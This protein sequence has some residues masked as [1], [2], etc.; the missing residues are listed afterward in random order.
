MDDHYHE[1][2][3]EVIHRVVD[4]TY[5][6]GGVSLWRTSGQPWMSDDR[7]I[8]RCATH[9]LA[10]NNVQAIGSPT[11]GA[12]ERTRRRRGAPQS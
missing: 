3:H 9:Y 10:I 8:A 4:V 11:V 6:N 5:V 7:F 2:R 1:R 12:S